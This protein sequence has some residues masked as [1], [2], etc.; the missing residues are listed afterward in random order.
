MEN[1]TDEMI[2]QSNDNSNVYINE[3]IKLL[4]PKR[5][6]IRKESNEKISIDLTKKRQ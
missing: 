5:A 1:A 6:M 3:K 4:L 2:I